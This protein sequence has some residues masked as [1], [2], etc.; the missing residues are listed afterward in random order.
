M[1][2]EYMNYMFSKV[3]YKNINEQ[4]KIIFTYFLTDTCLIL[5]LIDL[6]TINF[7]FQFRILMKEIF[8]FP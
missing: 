2:I 1:N 8:E 3:L 7:F 4:N 5:F 6:L